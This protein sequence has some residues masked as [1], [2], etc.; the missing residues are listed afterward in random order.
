MASMKDAFDECTNEPGVIWKYVWFSLPVFG[1]VYLYME[2]I[3]GF[4]FWVCAILGLINIIGTMTRVANN[5]MNFRE[6]T[7]PTY[8]PFTML[9]DFIRTSI[10]LL[11][12]I[13]LNGGI[14]WYLTTSI[15]P[16]YIAVEPVAKGVTYVTYGLCAAILLTVFML[17]AKRF[18][19]S[20]PFDIQAISNSC[21]DVL[22]HTIWMLVQLVFVNA[23][24]IGLVTYLFYVFI[25]MG[26][27]LMWFV[28]AM[29]AIFN[30]ALIG[31]YLGQLNHEA[32][33]QCEDKELEKQLR[34]E[35]N[36][37]RKE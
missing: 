23:F 15:Y 27:F 34:K 7:M 17:F 22:I 6:T 11:P 26:N 8:N 24:T 4:W 19:F 31:N 9:F 33:H 29:G 1:A 20:D 2:E 13:A 12:A 14:T 21:I 37:A 35:L 16:Q 5:C 25:G 3:M 32:L 28:W 18:R 10:A 36:D 30:A